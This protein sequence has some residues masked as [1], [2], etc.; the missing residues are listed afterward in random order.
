[1]RA[2][3]L[4]PARLARQRPPRQPAGRSAWRQPAAAPA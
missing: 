2:A 1:M 4:L 3:S